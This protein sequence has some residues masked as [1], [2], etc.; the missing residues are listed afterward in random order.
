[1][2]WKLL[3]PVSIIAA[4]IAFGVWFI[5]IGLIFGSVRPVQRHDS[6]LLASLIVPLVIA[7]LSGLFLYRHTSRRR[8]TQATITFLLTLIITAGTYFAGSRLFPNVIGIPRPCEPQSG[9]LCR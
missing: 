1:M 3:I 4:I 2:R 5:L 7:G 9:R 8:K 6:E